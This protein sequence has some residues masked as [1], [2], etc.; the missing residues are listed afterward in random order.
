MNYVR[1][2]LLDEGLHILAL[3]ETWLTNCCSNSFVDIPGF[4]LCRGDVS[5][6]IRKHGAAVYVS[7]TI[8]Y[9]QVEVPIPNVAVIQLIDY[10]IYV[11]SIYRPPSYLPRE[12]TALIELISEFVTNRETILL[13]DF[14][15]PS[16]NWTL[17]SVHGEYINP[18]DRLFHDCF[19][20]C[21]LVQWVKFPTFFPSG[22]ILDL[23]LTTDNDRIGEVCSVPPLP[24]CHH[25]PILC[26]V[27][28][29]FTPDKE[30]EG[31]VQRRQWRRA[32]FRSIS[33]DLI[34]VDWERS[35]EGLDVQQAYNLFSNAVN[36]SI[37]NHV[38]LTMRISKGK[39]MTAPPRELCLRRVNQWKKYKNVR[40]IYGRNST[41]ADYELTEYQR[42][43]HLYRNFS[44]IRQANYEQKLVDLLSEAPK[45]FHGYLRERKKGC[46]SVGPLK[47]FSG[48]LEQSDLGMSEIFADAFAS[49]FVPA[50]PASPH[51]YQHSN[52]HMQD[53]TVSY[54]TVRN[55]LEGISPSSSAG[56]DGIHPSILHRCSD[57]IALPL[58]IIIKK[59]LTDGS[60]PSE[61]K[62]SRVS[63][64]FK[65]G[66]KY[67]ALN[68]RPVS[69]TSATC[70]VAER[71]LANHIME[72][73]EEN[74]LLSG[75]QFGFRKGRSTEDQLLLSYGKI[76]REVDRGKVV[77]AVYLDYSK[78]FDVL[79]HSILLD[80]AESLG[81]SYQVLGWIRSFLE[82]RIL[83][84][85]V[86]GFCSGPRAVTSGVPQGSVLGPLLF[87]LYV[88]S[89]GYDF[90][91]EWYSFADD[92]KLFVS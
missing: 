60:L 10:D 61:W 47:D 77:D 69:V 64:I 79:S 7:D 15:L 36:I 17:D 76:A 70:K 72:Y 43:N 2:L 16:L 50:V 8:K 78:A 74:R 56:G 22:N 46:P 18:N 75:R 55:V 13:G 81:F 83:Q 57:V 67:D 82:N 6:S 14:N 38:P 30:D 33:Q 71:L 37:E 3:A 34:T 25:I 54:E 21:G 20:D 45:L 44:R 66:S 59:T 51:Q 88:N 65:T 42:L 41:E 31:L 62:H 40:R 90:N 35:L 1:N 68:Y 24:G 87:I 48:S 92:L 32:D 84:V 9:I 27:V 26:T 73:L 86:G 19:V 91:C 63:P 39:W 23:I 28:F 49:V 12:N 80:K 5:G 4:S 29:S 89:L 53:L 11:M 58:S 85:S 52:S